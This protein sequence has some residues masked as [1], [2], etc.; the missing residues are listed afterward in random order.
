MKFQIGVCL[1]EGLLDGIQWNVLYK[2]NFIAIQEKKPFIVIL[3]FSKNEFQLI[4]VYFKTKSVTWTYLWGFFFVFWRLQRIRNKT[5]SY[6]QLDINFGLLECYK[7][8]WLDI[9]ERFGNIC[10]IFIFRIFID[11]QLASKHKSSF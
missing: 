3:S 5:S 6:I 10:R 7:K 4:Y 8:S 2:E 11:L 9:I 1:V